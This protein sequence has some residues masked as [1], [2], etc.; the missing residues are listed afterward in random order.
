MYEETHKYFFA[1]MDNIKALVGQSKD[2]D[3]VI[4]HDKK[5]SYQVKAA[6]KKLDGHPN[7][8]PIETDDPFNIAFDP[9]T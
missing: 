9:D 5:K 2:L 3:V 6:M 4:L 1:M 7:V 8:V